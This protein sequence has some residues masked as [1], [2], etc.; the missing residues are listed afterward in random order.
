MRWAI[1]F[2]RVG[3]TAAFML[4]IVSLVLPVLPGWLFI[5]IGLYILSK[6][7]PGMQ[8]RI[9]ALRARYK[10]IETLMGHVERRMGH[11]HHPEPTPETQPLNKDVTTPESKV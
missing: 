6:D 9:R 3:G 10:R 2:R 8:G 4:G 5:G 7:S 11:V 1:L